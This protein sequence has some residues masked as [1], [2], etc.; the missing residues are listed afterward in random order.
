MLYHIQRTKD[1]AWMGLFKNADGSE[2]HPPLTKQ[3]LAELNH[4]AMWIALREIGLENNREA[5]ESWGRALSAATRTVRENATLHMNPS[6][7]TYITP[8]ISMERVRP[9]DMPSVDSSKID[10]ASVGELP[11][12]GPLPPQYE[13]PKQFGASHSVNERD[14]TGLLYRMHT[15]CSISMQQLQDGRWR[16]DL[17]D[18]DTGR[19]ILPDGPITRAS[20][21]ELNVS[22]AWLAARSQGM[23]LEDTSVKR[24]IL[25]RLETEQ[26]KLPPGTKRWETKVSLADIRYEEFQSLGNSPSFTGK[27][28]GKELILKELTQ[29]MRDSEKQAAMRYSIMERLQWDDRTFSPND[30]DVVRRPV[31]ESYRREVADAILKASS[32]FNLDPAL[33]AGVVEQESGGRVTA[34][35]FDRDL[36]GKSP[37]RF[38]CLGLMQVSP[39]YHLKAAQELFNG[40]DKVYGYREITDP[41]TDPK[42]AFF[43]PEVNIAVGC[44]I[45]K[46]Y[47]M[48]EKGT[49]TPEKAVDVLRKYN[50]G[51]SEKRPERI[52]AGTSYGENIFERRRTRFET[53]AQTQLRAPGSGKT[54]GSAIPHLFPFG[55]SAGGGDISSVPVS[56][57]ENGNVLSSRE[58]GLG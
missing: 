56:S 14:K 28:S 54:V 42:S 37:R 57:M 36:E 19:S 17:L 5:K 39:E 50:I 6:A 33:I 15:P 49:M 25:E 10:M 47:G 41:R 30:K 55:E 22:M 12:L 43:S 2:M 32:R 8:S 40:K 46:E 24:R 3:T 58:R 44:K 18:H 13:K 7:T 23:G 45:L 48:P 31:P 20:L 27:D 38:D 26:A 35:S 11:Q 53:G 21:G 51:P 16:G 52:E 9:G 34:I 29:K 4:S 1:G